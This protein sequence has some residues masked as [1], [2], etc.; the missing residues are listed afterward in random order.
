MPNFIIKTI[1]LLNW[2]HNK[3]FTKLLANTSDTENVSDKHTYTLSEDLSLN[4]LDSLYYNVVLKQNFYGDNYGSDW[5]IAPYKQMAHIIT[6]LFSPQC[7]LDIGC[8]KGLLVQAMIELQQ[9]SR[10]IDFSE[11]LIGKAHPSIQNYLTVAT[12]EDWLEKS[13]IKEVDLITFTEVFEHLPISILEQNLKYISEFYDGKL[14]ITIPSFGLDPTFKLGIRINN[15][16]LEWHRD[17]TDNIPFKNI[18]LEDGVPHH[19]H[20]TLASY[21]WWSELFLFHGYS[22]HRDL[23]FLCTDKFY[24]IFKTYNWHP[25]ILE[26]AANV[27]ELTKCLKTGSSLGCGWH[28]YEN[29]QGRWTDGL[30]RV[31]FNESNFNTN[32]LSL[33]VS[34][35]EINYIQECNLI[36]TI[37]NLVRTSS[38]KFK[39]EERYSAFPT[40]INT[41]E[42]KVNIKIDFVEACN[43][44]LTNENDISSN[45]WRINLISPSF[46]PNEY[47]ISSDIRRLGIFIHSIEIL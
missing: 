32:G 20:I 40:E 37:D 47:G 11:T 21:R 14:M 16:N 43:K 38:Y 2:F 4:E 45:C 13:S 30:A 19:G 35:P 44:N 34:A 29:S 10:G 17:M 18:V 26:K 5:E 23:E 3:K 33:E 25:Y 1:S 15:E 27:K 9:K 8:G 28:Q 39:W 42:A 46:C 12:A 36:V 6:S 24:N 7:H 41:R 31:Y 22:R